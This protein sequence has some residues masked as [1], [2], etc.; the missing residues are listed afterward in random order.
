MDHLTQEQMRRYQ[1]QELSSTEL[2]E[3]ADHLYQCLACRSEIQKS[4]EYQDALS[5]LQSQLPAQ[6]PHVSYEELSAY[7]DDK[8]DASARAKVETHLSRCQEC[9]ADLRDLQAIQHSLKSIPFRTQYRSQKNYLLAAALVLVVLAAG[10]F[11]STRITKS[12]S[13]NATG[14]REQLAKTILKDDARQLVLTRDGKLQSLSGV[15]PAMLAL[16]ETTMGAR[17]LPDSDVPVNL[18]PGAGTLLGTESAPQFTLSYPVGVVVLS[19]NPEFRWNPLPGA[20]SYTVTVLDEA[21]VEIA[22]SPALKETTWQPSTALERGRV[23]TWQVTAT[24]KGE[25]IISPVPPAPEA[26][27]KVLEGDKA[28]EILIAKQRKSPH[29]LLAILYA[30]S[31]LREEARKEVEILGVQNPGSPIVS[32]LV[33]SLQNGR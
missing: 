11:M 24:K 9:E 18:N 7:V 8:A 32:G 4:P 2:S 10:W 30:R 12:Q 27:F 22:A 29:L 5:S 26:I 23:Y 25:E 31:G 3:F 6:A 16:M 14:H 20:E 28:R 17:R 13:A 33:K 19:E 1:K 15:S 21:L